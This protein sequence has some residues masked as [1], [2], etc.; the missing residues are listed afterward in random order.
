MPWN[1]LA[2]AAFWMTHGDAAT[3]EPS[4]GREIAEEIHM[5]LTEMV[6]M[7]WHRPSTLASLAATDALLGNSAEAINRLNE[8]IDNGYKNQ[9]LGIAHPAFNT[10]RD[11][12]E[13]AVAIERMYA[14]IDEEEVRLA[15]IQLAPYTPPVQREPIAVASETL[16]SY[17]GWYSNGNQM[18]QVFMANDGR[19]MFTY[20]PSPAARLLAIAE[21][22]F[23]T[24][25]S[26]DF[27]IQFFL[28]DDG[29]S[30]HFLLKGAFGD[31]RLKRV[32]DPPPFIQ[33]PREV[34]ARYEGTFAYDRM[35]GLEGER[36]EADY[37]VA[38][39]YVDE[40]GKIWIDYDNQPKL[41]IA[42]YSETEFQ[43]VGMEAQYRFVV[44]PDSGKYNDFIRSGDGNEK[45]F[46]RQ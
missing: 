23:F 12:S 46:Y 42:A 26:K 31:M 7:G 27:T 29:A 3:S 1:E 43:L 11:L 22:E 45:H 5:R 39:I 10:I 40:A 44:D 30:T 8:A 14:L 35:S 13:F 41:E 25:V 18:S 16:R 6:D 37:W 17:E 24:P 15:N 19:F 38:E 33:L 28:N 4:R 34:L 9:T 21:D 2:V 32:E 36:T 20:G